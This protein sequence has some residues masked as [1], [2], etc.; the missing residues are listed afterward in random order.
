MSIET[1]PVQYKV[2]V[3]FE[4]PKN[5]DCQMVIDDL[6]RI[7]PM[8][9]VF[10]GNAACAPYIEQVTADKQEAIMLDG[11]WQQVAGRMSGIHELEKAGLNDEAVSRCVD[12][13]WANSWEE[14]E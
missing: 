12:A 4:Y 13:G 2:R 5:A 14:D 7:W 9:D 11:Q 8:A 6:E 3:D 1:I 10:P